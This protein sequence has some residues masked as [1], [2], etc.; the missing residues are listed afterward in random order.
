MTNNETNIA[1]L[2]LDKALVSISAEV[3]KLKKNHHD[4]QLI[5]KFLIDLTNALAD[6][7]YSNILH[8]WEKQQ[9]AIRKNLLRTNIANFEIEGIINE[10]KMQRA[11]DMQNFVQKFPIAADSFGLKIDG[12]SR[13]PNYYLM[14]G[15]IHI[16]VN[17]K[18]YQVTITP[19]MGKAILVGPEYD[20]IFRT[21]KSEVRRIFGRE[22]DS[23]SFRTK[24]I[25]IYKTMSPR[26][27]QSRSPEVSIK[28]VMKEFKTRHKMSPD[29][30][31]IDFSLLLKEEKG[32]QLGNTRDSENGIQIVGSESNGYYGYMRIEEL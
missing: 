5:E 25:E 23:L 11:E 14:N 8:A 7:K 29:E 18:K 13:H 17:E 26:N 1:P 9:D 16:S 4:A 6:K 2:T 24:L 15:F 32:I 3:N 19:R 31:L 12:N 21:L 27:T 30:F 28:A 20:E 22:W 10:L